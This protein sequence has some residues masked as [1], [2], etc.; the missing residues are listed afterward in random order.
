LYHSCAQ[1]RTE[2]VGDFTIMQLIAAPAIGR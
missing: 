2:L 1:L